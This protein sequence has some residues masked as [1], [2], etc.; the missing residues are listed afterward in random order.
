LFACTHAQVVLRISV[1]LYRFGLH[2]TE[3]IYAGVYFGTRIIPLEQNLN[4]QKDVFAQLFTWKSL[5]VL[6]NLSSMPQC[7]H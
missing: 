2:P 5:Q 1:S 3:C 6:A 4:S 7:N